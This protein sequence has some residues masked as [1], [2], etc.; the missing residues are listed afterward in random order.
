[1][2]KLYKILLFFAFCLLSFTLS[3]A[4]ETDTH[5]LINKHIVE[6]NLYG[7]SLDS[8]LKNQLGI[9]N[10]IKEEFKSNET[11]KVWEWIKIGG[12]YEDIP[13]WF[14]PY[15]RS[16]NHFHDP[17][18]NKGY[19]GFWGSGV[20][21]GM[22]SM[23]WAQL[24]KGAQSPLSDY[25]RGGNYSWHD[26]RDYFYK[27][28]ALKDKKDRETNFAEMFRGLGQVMH[29]VED[30]SVPAHTRNDGHAG[31]HYEVWVKDHHKLLNLNPIGFDKSIL[32][33]LPPSSALLPITNIFDTDKYD[34][35]NLN[36]TFSNAIGIAE[37]TNANFFSEETV[38]KNYSHLTYTDTNYFDID[39]N[40]P[41]I[42]DA[43]DGKLDRRIYVRKTVGEADPRLAALSYIAYD[44]I[45]KG[46][47]EFSPLVLDDEVY[48]DYASLLIPRAVG[49]SAGLLNYFFRGEMDMVPDEEKGSG[50]V[51]ENNTDEDMNG[52]F[53]LWYDNDKDERVKVTDASWTL[54]I[55]KK[56]SGN[57]KSTN[58]TFTPPTDAKEPDK[59]MLVFMGR[60]GNEEDAVVGKEISLI[61]PLVFLIY[62]DAYAVW[63]ISKNGEEL[64][65]VKF[66]I[67]KYVTLI[68]PGE[69]KF[70]SS[71]KSN[72]KLNEHTAMVKNFQS[73]RGATRYG[74]Y[75]QDADNHFYLSGLRNGYVNDVFDNSYAYMGYNINLNNPPAYVCSGRNSWYKE[76]KDI[77][78][79]LE[80]WKIGTNIFQTKYKVN[81]VTTNGET[82][83]NT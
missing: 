63:S 13:Y 72:S 39:W 29:L 70:P 30:A 55:N 82:I 53:E 25:V 31:Y 28:L 66:D 24:P 42:I 81:G 17:I 23:I 74:I 58:I 83:N 5:E 48:N 56:S 12:K 76:N 36:I 7:F 62:Q 73:Q 49:Y 57:N 22:S 59:Y 41:E 79:D 65:D 80:L 35:S 3:F 40:H 69:R 10:G 16:V 43:E 4:L 14:M 15:L 20:M 8:Y 44:G 34:G 47:Y 38:F 67:P 78:S 37:Y 26:T 21:S 6:N 45:K 19:A 54:S 52:T 71:V 64:K 32:N 68:S 46:Y 1:M 11:K 75:E 33:L 60:L 50:Y 27:A 9:Q 2:R 61:P 51:I 18:S 77:I